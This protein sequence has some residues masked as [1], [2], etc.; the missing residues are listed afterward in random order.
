MKHARPYLLASAKTSNPARATTAS[1]DP[2]RESVRH[3]GDFPVVELRRYTIKNGERQNFADYF[4]SFFPEAFE[5]I[6]AIAF[7]QFLERDDRSRFTWLRGFHSM[8]DRASLNGAFYDGPLWKEHRS[9]VNAV[10][11]DSDDVL[12]LRALTPAGGIPV[13]PAVDPVREPGGAHGIV[14]AQIFATRA[15]RVE[16]FARRAEPAFS[17]YRAVGAREAGVLATLDEPNNFPRH[18]I[19]TDGPFLVWLGIVEN[20][21]IVETVFR[22]LA[23]RSAR[24]LVASRLLRGKAEFVVLRPTRRSRLRWL[25]EASR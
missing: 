2:A 13:F 24:D 3:L 14:V 1:A 11:V 4:E 15:G 7:G 12:L 23:E 18:P 22:P 19:R 9:T 20:D 16:A 17:G 21:E 25:P 5:Q 6:G 8:D 10:I